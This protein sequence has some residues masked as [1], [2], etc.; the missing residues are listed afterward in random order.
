MSSPTT[1]AA[2]HLRACLGALGWDAAGDPELSATPDAVAGW[3][4]SLDPQAP[5]PELPLFDAP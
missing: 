2:D 3:L 5:L 1:S 4:A